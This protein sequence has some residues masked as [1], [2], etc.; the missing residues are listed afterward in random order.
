MFITG[1]SYYTTM[2]KQ[3]LTTGDIARK[4]GMD[5]K[6]GRR[7]VIHVIEAMEL[8]PDHRTGNYRMYTLSDLRLIKRYN[9]LTEYKG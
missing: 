1:T 2:S 3:F 9:V 5:T 7:R 4:L 6:R 8:D